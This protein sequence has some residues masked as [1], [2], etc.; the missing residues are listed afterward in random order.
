MLDL[1]DVERILGLAEL[2]T[3]WAIVARGGQVVD[4]NVVA[5]VGGVHGL[6]AA[7]SAGPEDAPR[8]RHLS[9]EALHLG[10]VLCNRFFFKVMKQETETT[11]SGFLQ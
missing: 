2:A 9:H 8:P 7:G 10:A 11:L 6:V 1:V 4:L 5:H 3:L